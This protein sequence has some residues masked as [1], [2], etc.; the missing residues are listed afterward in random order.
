MVEEV[1]L[2]LCRFRFRLSIR[3]T[4]ERL[5]RASFSGTS[6]GEVELGGQGVPV[7]PDQG[8]QPLATEAVEEVPYGQ[9]GLFHRFIVNPP[10]DPFP[11]PLGEYCDVRRLIAYSPQ[12]GLPCVAEQGDGVLA[13]I[14]GTLTK[15]I[16]DSAFFRLSRFAI[17]RTGY[18]RH[19]FFCAI[20]SLMVTPDF[21]SGDTYS[22]PMIRFLT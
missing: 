21:L 4:V 14:P 2:A 10:V 13:G 7:R 18:V 19:C 16:P 9:N 17:A 22:V 1:P 5:T 3:S 8:D 20:V 11:T 15:R 6:P 12:A